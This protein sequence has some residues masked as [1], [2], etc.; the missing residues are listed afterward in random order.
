MKIKIKIFGAVLI[1]LLMFTVTA[2]A[3]SHIYLEPSDITCNPGEVTNITI[4][5]DSTEEVTYFQ[6]Q[7][8]YSEGEVVDIVNI[9]SSI[10]GTNP[11]W[12]MWDSYWKNG[13]SAIPNIG[14]NYLFV[15]ATLLSSYVTGEKI[16][17]AKISVKGLNPGEMPLEIL[18]EAEMTM[19]G[20]PTEMGDITGTKIPFTRINGSFTCIGPAETFEKTLVPNW[21]LVSLPLTPSDN[22]LATVLL[23][24][25][26]SYDAVKSYNASI[27]EFEDATTMDPGTGYFIHMTAVDTWSYEGQAFNS[28][29]ES[30]ITG[31]NC[32][33]WEN[34]S[35]SLP[36]ALSSIDYRY[37]S[38]WNAD[39]QKYEVYDVNAP[40]TGF[41]DFDIMERGKGYFIAATADCPLDP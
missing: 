33:G 32:V 41:N 13:S 24:I 9:T 17:M 8:K 25:N 6:L 4:Y 23:S 5:M 11:D 40:T 38:R 19:Q 28:L 7:L 39:D 1:L 16:E 35:A 26:G 34:A 3:D 30:L 31:L 2:M 12:I 36:D 15:T 21:N 10:E 22:S 37:V 14:H 18:T 27:N 20:D 29:S